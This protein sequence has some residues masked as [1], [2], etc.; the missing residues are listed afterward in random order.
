[1]AAATQPPLDSMAALKAQIEAAAR[2]YIV[3][4][5]TGEE[6]VRQEFFF[7]LVLSR[8]QWASC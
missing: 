5:R 8:S 7:R 1:M 3:E 6:D 2:D 4:P